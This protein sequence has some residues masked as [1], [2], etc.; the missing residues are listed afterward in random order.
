[1]LN[2]SLGNRLRGEADITALVDARIYQDRLGQNS[3]MPAICWTVVS[4]VPTYSVSG[5]SNLD[6]TLIQ[7]DCY[8]RRREETDRLANLVFTRLVDWRGVQ[9]GRMVDAVIFEN[10]GQNFFE[11]D[12]KLFRTL[13]EIRIISHEV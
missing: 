7:I 3:A 9:D 8:S 12:T 4:I 13:M 1:M 6:D 11:N 10:R 2:G 5:H